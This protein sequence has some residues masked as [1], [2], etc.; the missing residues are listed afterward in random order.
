MT[1]YDIETP[2]ICKDLREDNSLDIPA[3]A[4]WSLSILNANGASKTLG[5]FGLFNSRFL[6]F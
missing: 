3:K 5:S 1:L 6:I 2:T 4:T